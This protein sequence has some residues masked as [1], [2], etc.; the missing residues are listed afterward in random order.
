MAQTSFFAFDPAFTGG[1]RLA[2]A[3]IDGDGRDDFLVTPGP[4]GGPTFRAVSAN[5]LATLDM[6]DVLDPGFRGGL[7]PAGV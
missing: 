6:F 4:G 5:G 2:A 3:D 1:V 7:Y